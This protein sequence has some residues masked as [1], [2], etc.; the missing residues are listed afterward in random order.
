MAADPRSERPSTLG[1]STDLTIFNASV[2]HLG[3]AP[4]DLTRKR[5]QVQTLSRPPSRVAERGAERGQFNDP[6]PF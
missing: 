6:P 5:S 3:D 1:F 2:F 4:W